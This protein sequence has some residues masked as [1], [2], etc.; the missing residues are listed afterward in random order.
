[1]AVVRLAALED[2][3]NLSAAVERVTAAGGSGA[4]SPSG[5][6]TVAAPPTREKKTTPLT[7][8]AK[9]LATSSGPASGSGPAAPSAQGNRGA[10]PQ[11]EPPV[12]SVATTKHD[13]TPGAEPPPLPAN[14]A[15]VWHAVASSLDGFAADFAATALAV[16]WKA[17][18]LEVTLP[19]EAAAA[20]TFL[21][22]PDSQAAIHAALEGHLG[23]PMRYRIVLAPPVAK[24]PVRPVGPPA[25]SQA[26]LMKTAMDHP[27]VV[28]ARTLFDAAV[29]K[30]EPLR[31]SERPAVVAAVPSVIDSADT[32]SEDEEV[33]A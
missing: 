22:R 20:A 23:R 12:L 32:P 29:R 1:M 15:A 18:T 2:L 26:T 27:F 21:G 25:Q 17:D 30:V 6:R 28:H 31:A 3:E 7:D 8:V 4:A 13:G 10:A 19:A 14:A 9:P 33:D 11:D 5:P 24:P 16:A